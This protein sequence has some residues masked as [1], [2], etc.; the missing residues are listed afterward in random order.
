MNVAG[1]QR[2]LFRTGNALGVWAYRTTNGKVGG[3]AMGGSPVLLLTV[4]G[5]STGQPHTVPVS[6]VEHDGGWLVCGSAGGAPTDPQWFRN[7]RALAVTDTAQVRLRSTTYDVAVRV[8]DGTDRAEAFAAFV[9]QAP[10]FAGYEDRTGGR[11]LPVAL[12]TPVT[13]VT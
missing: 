2:R 11:L 9:A 1:L 13:A 6:Y 12:L 7:L 10:G 5:R 4:K 8:L 3:R